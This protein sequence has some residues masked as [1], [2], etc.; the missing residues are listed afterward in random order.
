[1]VR[2]R[3]RAGLGWTREDQGREKAGDAEWAGARA[4]GPSGC[5]WEQWPAPPAHRL[6]TAGQPV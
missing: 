6:G 5:L 3:H 1:M 4:E 2:S